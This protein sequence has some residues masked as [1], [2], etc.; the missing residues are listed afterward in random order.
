MLLRHRLFSLCYAIC[1]LPA[2]FIAGP[3]SKFEGHFDY[4]VFFWIGF[5]LPSVVGS[6]GG[7]TLDAD[8][9][10]C[11]ERRQ[12][13][14]QRDRRLRDYRLCRARGGRHRRDA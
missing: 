8:A 9:W 12:N 14:G 10:Y 5:L 3:A 13:E 7:S 2:W 6:L 4:E 11:G 1:I